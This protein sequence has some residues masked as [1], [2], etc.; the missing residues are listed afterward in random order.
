[1]AAQKSLEILKKASEDVNF[2]DYIDG[3]VDRIIQMLRNGLTMN[4]VIKEVESPRRVTE[5]CF[6]LARSR[7]EVK[8]KFAHWDRLWFDSYTASYSTPEVV[9]S[10]RAKRLSGENILDAGCGAGIQ[11]IYFSLEGS[12]TV[13]VEKDIGRYYMSRINAG[14]MGAKLKI[15]RGDVTALDPSSLN[16]ISLIFSD[17][18][19]PPSQ[20]ERDLQHLIPSPGV[21][22]SHFKTVTEDFVFDIP[23]QMRWNK[24]DMDGEKEYI[25]VSGR[26]NRL[27]VYLGRFRRSDVSA[28]MLPSGMR[29][30]GKPD[31]SENNQS[32][33]V[34]RYL[35]VVDPSLVYAC[36]WKQLENGS[37]DYLGKDDRRIIL[38]SEELIGSFP[39][40][41]FQVV[42]AGSD[43][44]DIL[45][46]APVGRIFPRYSSTDYY[47]LKRELEGL[48]GGGPDGHVFRLPGKFVL[49]VKL[50]GSVQGPT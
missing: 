42:S 24:I 13:A 7:L 37:V 1:M 6:N 8:D 3:I 21:I 39:G 27:T 14:V 10:Y 5:F 47:T 2:R 11:A 41:R 46:G 29:F 16:K 23:P 44:K 30:Q 12:E 31:C 15:V 18:E 38:T 26:L 33:Q 43:I 36:L 25:S 9:A 49:A 17:P 20:I 45:K 4:S 28:V 32:G 48:T 40:E 22:M 34:K 19:R 50:P 35:Y